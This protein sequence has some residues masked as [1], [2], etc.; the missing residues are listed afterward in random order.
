MI[1]FGT[2]PSS[3]SGSSGR[4]AFLFGVA[5]CG[6]C[7]QWPIVEHDPLSTTSPTIT[8]TTVEC[9]VDTAE[10]TITVGTDAWTGNGTLYLSA[11]GAYIEQHTLPSTSAPADGSADTL[12]RNLSIVATWRDAVANSSTAFGCATPDLAGIANVTSRDGSAVTDCV[13]FGVEPERW[14]R[15]N[16][17]VACETV[18]SED[19]G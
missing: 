15:W 4:A 5:L 6:G 9:D 13:A 3:A 1:P 7:Y 14:W 17:D 8:S 16:P 19:S 12:E 10:W 2:T 18:L 11:D